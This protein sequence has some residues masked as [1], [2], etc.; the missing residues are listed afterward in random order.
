MAPEQEQAGPSRSLRLFPL[1]PDDDDV[2]A[3]AMSTIRVRRLGILICDTEVGSPP[4]RERHRE[5]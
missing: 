5:E 4:D 1:A 2:L 3:S